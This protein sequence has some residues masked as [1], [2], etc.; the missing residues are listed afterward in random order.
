M[1]D[2]PLLPAEFAGLDLLATMVVV[3]SADGECLFANAAFENVMRL[4]RRAVQ[5]AQLPD[6]FD[7]AQRLVETLAGVAANQ[8][9]SSRF[10]AVLRRGA[11]AH[12]DGL[13]VH[14]IVSQMDACLLYTS[15]SPR[16]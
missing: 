7:D 10:D 3:V 16:D 15:P 11:W 6:W 2:T 8:Y 1:T 13:L 12:E 9:S 14:V 4:S 5:K